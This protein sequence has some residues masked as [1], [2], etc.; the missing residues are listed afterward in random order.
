MLIPTRRSR[1]LIVY[2]NQFFLQC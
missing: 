2:S 1:K